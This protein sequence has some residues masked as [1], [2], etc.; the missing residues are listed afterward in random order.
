MSPTPLDL[1]D[2]NGKV[3]WS[4]VETPAEETARLA[5]EE[6][7]HVFQVR[8]RWALFWVSVLAVTAAGGVGAYLAVTGQSPEQARM[9][10][11]ILSSVLTG[12][13][14]FLTGRASA[15]SAKN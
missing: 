2:A 9:G 12:A 14:G 5:R 8:M 1:N 3:E 7:E 13:F 15:S 4:T 11:T 10:V 6:R